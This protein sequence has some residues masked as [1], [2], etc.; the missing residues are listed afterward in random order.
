M[1]YKEVCGRFTFPSSF[2]FT[3]KQDEIIATFEEELISKLA[4]KRPGL[5]I[6]SR[7][8]EPEYL[9][10]I[11]V[12]KEPLLFNIDMKD[13]A[14]SLGEVGEKIDLKHHGSIAAL[15]TTSLINALEKVVGN[16]PLIGYSVTSKQILDLNNLKNYELLSALVPNLVSG[17]GLFTHL[18]GKPYEVQRADFDCTLFDKKNDLEYRIKLQAP[19]N[20]MWRKLWYEFTVRS[21]EE[22]IC[23]PNILNNL[24]ATIQSVEQG[25]DF[26][27]HLLEQDKRI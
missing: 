27:H 6:R 3:T 21:R 8:K 24:E 26:L 2:G 5:S 10:I 14:F 15:Y 19:S 22:Q 25:Q 20:D 17:N 16:R 7:A 12:K 18:P 9:L 11:N 23:N 4:P 1:D 13:V